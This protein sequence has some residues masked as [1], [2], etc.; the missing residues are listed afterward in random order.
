MTTKLPASFL[1]AKFQVLSGSALKLIAI[2]L[3]L[4]DHTGLMIL[5]NYPATTATLFSFGGVDYSWYRI[6]RDIGRAAFPIFC[7]LLV[8]G[9]LHTHNRK[10]YGLNLFLFAC[11]SEIPWNF[12]FTN[13]WRYEKQNVFF[14][15]FLGYLAFC[16][17]EYF[18]DNQKMQ[19]VCVLA[20]LTVSVF[21]KADYGWRGFVFLLSMYWFRNDKTAQAIFGSCCLYYEW[22][23]CFAFLSINMYNGERGFVKGKFLKYVFYWFYPV[24]ITIL[25]ILRKLLFH[26]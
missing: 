20:L 25:V 23:A 19:L 3:M 9:F 6:F 22:K 21:L 17:L 16:A 15:L 10:K 12:M 26:M 24:H 1:P 14:T 2:A 13:T 8:E 5:Y 4:I 7:F 18:W 11:I